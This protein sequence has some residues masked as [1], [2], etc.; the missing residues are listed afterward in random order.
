[1]K[2]LIRLAKMAGNVLVWAMIIATAC[3]VFS[4][5]SYRPRETHK[6][7]S[8]YIARYERDTVYKLD[9]V[10]VYTLRDTVYTDRWRYV[11]RDRLVRD[12][13]YKSERDTITNVVEVE[14]RLTKVQQLKMDI[15]AGVMWA[16]PILMAVGLF[17]LY[18]KLR[19]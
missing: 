10:R 1:M 13:I 18:C 15:G 8:S 5:T 9:S 7:D 3:A 12:T 11:Y 16:V 14:K 6:V 17:V 4:C 19:K 2:T